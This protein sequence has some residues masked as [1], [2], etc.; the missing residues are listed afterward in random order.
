MLLLF[1]DI[2]SFQK[3]D[4]FPASS[5][6]NPVFALISSRVA[7]LAISVNTKPFS[8]LSKTAFSVTTISTIYSPVMGKVQASTNL[9]FPPTVCNVATATLH[10]QET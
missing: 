8:P 5:I 4:T 9:D 3:T 6:L 2:T 7:L 1:D 10:P